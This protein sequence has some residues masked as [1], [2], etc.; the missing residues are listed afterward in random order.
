ML[1]TVCLFLKFS[2]ATEMDTEIVKPIAPQQNVSKPLGSNSKMRKLRENLKMKKLRENSK[3]RNKKQAT[4]SRAN[5]I[6]QSQKEPNHK[7]KRRRKK[8][9]VNFHCPF[10]ECGKAFSKEFS[11][12]NHVRKVH[13]GNFLKPTIWALRNL[14]NFTIWLV[15]TRNAIPLPI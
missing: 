14:I 9:E 6:N 3:K 12:H 13:E 7:T 2:C 4:R 8:M 11:V 5:Q 15:R 1:N 10:K